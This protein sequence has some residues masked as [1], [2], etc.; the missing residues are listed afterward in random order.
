MGTRGRVAPPSEVDFCK[1]CT[2]NLLCL[3]IYFA[4]VGQWTL[5][6]LHS[7]WDEGSYVLLQ[8]TH[9]PQEP[10]LSVQP[11]SSQKVVQD[12]DMKIINKIKPTWLMYSLR[13]VYAKESVWNHA[14]LESHHDV[15]S[16]YTRKTHS[17]NVK[18]YLHHCGTFLFESYFISWGQ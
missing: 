15:K 5:P 17:T 4:S 3:G 18:N 9:H 2:K 11:K 1:I 16:S 10:K 12:H 14:L 7:C 8:V 13:F 6:A